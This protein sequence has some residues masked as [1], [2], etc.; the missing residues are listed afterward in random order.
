[1]TTGSKI[2]DLRVRTNTACGV[3]MTGAYSSRVWSGKDG[4][5]TENAYTCTISASMNPVIR[6]RRPGEPWKNG[7]VSSCF[8]GM[9]VV[10][11][12]STEM[13]LLR[14][15]VLGGVLGKYKKHSF[16]ASVLLGELPETARMVVDPI[17]DVLQ[18]YRLARKGKF[19][20][21]RK[22]LEDRS[23]RRIPID[24]GAASNWLAL[25]YGWIPA[26][27]DSY[28]AA[29]AYHLWKTTYPSHFTRV[30]SKAKIET[31]AFIPSCSA[32]GFNRTSL[33]I[34]LKTSFE[35]EVQSTL[36]FGNPAILAW[37]LL[38][39]SFVV[40][41]AYDVGTW[42][43]LVCQLPRNRATQ[44]ITTEF[45]QAFVAGPVRHPTYEV[46]DSESYLNKIVK[47]T[48]SSSNYPFVPPPVMRN[49]FGN[50]ISRLLDAV[51]IARVLR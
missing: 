39:F 7:A 50:S 5:T 8:G 41:W 10:K 30:R 11:P 35:L 28:N 43:E 12:T 31:P 26:I 9:T 14:T 40:D 51:S 34:I 2:Q 4:K 36:G 6:F 19:S 38:P 42:L 32:R 27:Q 18:A 16:N 20:K 17:I 15:R 37:E 48:R 13:A 29:E 23:G 21:A 45:S 47:V 33:S 49:P 25:R 24:K 46:R 44:Y 3:A 1:M 22:V